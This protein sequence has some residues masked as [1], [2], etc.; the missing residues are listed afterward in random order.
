MLCYLRQGGA[1]PPTRLPPFP[2]SLPLDATTAHDSQQPKS[3]PSTSCLLSHQHMPKAPVD[4]FLV[5]ERVQQRSSIQQEH[6]TT[7]AGKTTVELQKTRDRY[8]KE[9]ERESGDGT[10]NTITRAAVLEI[11]EQALKSI[12]KSP[13][14]HKR[15]DT[16]ATRQVEVVLRNISAEPNDPVFRT[17]SQILKPLEPQYAQPLIPEFQTSKKPQDTNAHRAQHRLESWRDDG[18]PEKYP[19]R[20]VEREKKKGR[21]L[22]GRGRTK[23]LELRQ[24][25]V[26]KTNEELGGIVEVKRGNVLAE[27]ASRVPSVRMRK[28]EDGNFVPLEKYDDSDDWD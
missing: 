2:I 26:D 22:I 10:Q 20:A 28:N 5:D 18:W 17:A 15:I 3:P 6:R 24:R 16:E 27:K 11:Y 25:H 13:D 1:P 14:L 7:P 23:D 4:D 8:A 9:T 21:N 19:E 12:G